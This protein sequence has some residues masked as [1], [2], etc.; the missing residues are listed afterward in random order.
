MGQGENQTTGNAVPQ[1][2]AS[3]P[4]RC[5]TLPERRRGW[6]PAE[7]PE[8]ESWY[9]EGRPDRQRPLYGALPSGRRW[10]KPSRGRAPGCSPRT[11]PAAAAPA[12]GSGRSA[13]GTRCPRPGPR[14]KPRT[15]RAPA[16]T[17]GPAQ[18]QPPL[19]PPPRAAAGWAAAGPEGRSSLLGARQGPR[20]RAAE[21]GGRRSGNRK[22]LLPR[23]REL[24]SPRAEAENKNFPEKSPRGGRAKG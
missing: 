15:A 2:Q 7:P 4:G 1:M 23:S 5:Q 12:R 3:N 16:P 21:G 24:L 19:P 10:S 22:V 18:R 6:L 13:D 14:R 9:R 17:P 8:P 11:S 20:G